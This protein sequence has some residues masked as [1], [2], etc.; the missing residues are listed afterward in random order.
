MKTATRP[1]REK[2][3]ARS[4]SFAPY[5]ARPG[6]SAFDEIVWE[7]RT[8][9]ITADTGKAMFRQENIEV[10]AAWSEL[11]TKIVASK[12]FYGDATVSADPAN[13]GR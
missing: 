11:A 12:Y 1:A 2:S 8:A 6:V 9:E 4:H 3:P 10:P 7:R 13:D 5:F